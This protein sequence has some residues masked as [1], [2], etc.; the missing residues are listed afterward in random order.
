VAARLGYIDDQLLKDLERELNSVGAPL[1]GL[2]R[3]TRSMPRVI[4]TV[5]LSCG[6]FL[7]RH[8]I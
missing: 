7:G 4:P 3:S 5:A 8:F 1:A 2:I 6:L